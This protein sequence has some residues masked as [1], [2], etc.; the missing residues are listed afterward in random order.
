M[1]S[2]QGWG[3]A[4]SASEPNRSWEKPRRS[5][6][7]PFPPAAFAAGR[8]SF[9]QPWFAPQ[10]GIRF[11]SEVASPSLPRKEIREKTDEDP[12]EPF[13]HG[14]RV[15]RGRSFS[16]PILPEGTGNGG[17]TPGGEVASSSLPEKLGP[18]ARLRQ[19]YGGQAGIGTPV[20]RSFSEGGS[21]PTSDGQTG[22]RAG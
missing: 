19:G 16:Q 2:P 4:P 12:L 7:E 17:I 9:L 1:G 10:H 3:K 20:R 22:R 8:R 11:S 14:T 5:S 21:L 15:S 6:L 18:A 13:P